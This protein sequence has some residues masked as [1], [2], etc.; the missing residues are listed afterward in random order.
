MLADSATELEACSLLAHKAATLKDQGKPF[1]KVAAMAKYACSE[2][3]NRV[4]D[5]AVQVHG[6]YGFSKDYPV[7]RYYRDARVLRIYEGTS[8]VQKIVIARKVLRGEE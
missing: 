6:G 7:E 8:E 3:V 1:T 4:A 5:N 2:M